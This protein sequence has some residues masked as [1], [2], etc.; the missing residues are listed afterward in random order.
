MD[1][2]H[3]ER[4]FTCLK[5]GQG[6]HCCSFFWLFISLSI[7][8]IVH[9][10][11][12][13]KNCREELLFRILS[14]SWEASW[15]IS[16][17]FLTSR[18][19]ANNP[20]SRQRYFCSR[21]IFCCWVLQWGFTTSLPSAIFREG[22]SLSFEISDWRYSGAYCRLWH[23]GQAFLFTKNAVPSLDYII[24]EC[25]YSGDLP[26]MFRGWDIRWEDQPFILEIHWRRY[27]H[28]L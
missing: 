1:G 4:A 24:S 17:I 6:N 19:V 28:W 12:F 10:L 8:T 9:S 3:G 5:G 22:T 14:P 25:V 15:G 26:R 16:Q 23:Q 20:P 18:L 2:A 27:C 11:L 13:S 21:V 7:K